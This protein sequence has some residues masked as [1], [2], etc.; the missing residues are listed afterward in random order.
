[1]VSFV[2][3]TVNIKSSQENALFLIEQ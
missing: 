3:S 1:M 2:D